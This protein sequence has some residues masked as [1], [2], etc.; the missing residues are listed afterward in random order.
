VTE[1]TAEQTPE[2]A[3]RD[4]IEPFHS[5]CYFA[6]D[7]KARYL[8]LGMH[9]WASYF[10]QRAAP[11]GAVGAEVVT[12]T[13]YGFSPSLVAK[14]VPTVWSRLSPEQ[15]WEDRVSSVGAVLARSV[16]AATTDEDLERAIAIGE[17]MVSAFVPGG[18]PLGTAHAAMPRP[19][20]RLP[21][22]WVVVSALREYR[23]DGH[24]AA[25]V[26]HGVGPLESMA[27]STG[28][29][30]LSLRFHQRGRGWSEDDWSAGVERARVAGWLDDSG[31]LTDA[32]ESMRQ[33]VERS[34][35]ATM[36][37]VIGAVS[38]PDAAFFTK[39]VGALSRTLVESGG[40]P[41]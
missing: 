40:F 29:S 21:H 10:G 6:E 26:T 28:Y 39:L 35:D 32:G 3:L 5:I 1:I 34:T 37:E 33:N 8:E 24:V 15:A 30:N 12:S 23:G 22:L 17:Q 25:L 2:R 14:S 4:A 41:A 31:R 27:T 7:V 13:F 16:A 20:G 36:S 9:P 18:R 38:Q 11:M 19:P